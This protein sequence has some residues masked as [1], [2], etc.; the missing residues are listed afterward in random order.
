MSQ[1]HNLLLQKV[2]NRLPYDYIDPYYQTFQDTNGNYNVY[3]THWGPFRIWSADNPDSN[4]CIDQP[5]ESEIHSSHFLQVYPSLHHLSDTKLKNQNFTGTYQGKDVCW[6][7]SKKQWTYLNHKPVNS[8]ESEQ[9]QVAQTLDTAQ[10][11][12]Q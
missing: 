9:A 2:L 5:I 8:I 4:W 6:S 10:Q 12:I 11:T 7:H 3:F 1:V